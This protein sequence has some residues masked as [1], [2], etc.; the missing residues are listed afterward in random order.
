MITTESQPTMPITYEV[1]EYEVGDRTV[2]MIFTD[3]E[4]FVH[5]RQVNIPYNSDGTVDEDYLQEIFEGQYRGVINK[6]KIGIIT[7]TDPT[8]I[9]EPVGIAST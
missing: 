9:P 7:F 4:G 6:K 1:A 5:K 3:D 8:E 2:E